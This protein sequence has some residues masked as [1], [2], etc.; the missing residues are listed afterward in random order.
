MTEEKTE[1]SMSAETEGMR[2]H[3]DD[4][5]R[6]LAD[7]RE[8]GD[9]RTIELKAAWVADLILDAER[10]DEADWWMVAYRL[11]PLCRKLQAEIARLNAD[12]RTV[13]NRLRPWCNV[14][15][16]GDL[17]NALAIAERHI[18]KGRGK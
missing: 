2:T 6:V 12:W 5:D 3:A 11:R 15:G 18:N 1:G 10:D 17:A 13:A 4:R 9:D 14:A 8:L 7:C 16:S